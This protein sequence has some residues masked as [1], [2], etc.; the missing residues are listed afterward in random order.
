MDAGSVS[1]LRA[2]YDDAVRKMAA[3]TGKPSDV[4]DAWKALVE[5]IIRTERE[6]AEIAKR[7]RERGSRIG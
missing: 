1:E 7:E 6:N 2:A 3:G 4:E 5:V